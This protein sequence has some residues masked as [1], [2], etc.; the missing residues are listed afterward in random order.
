MKK[1]IVLALLTMT[2]SSCGPMNWFLD[3]DDNGNDMPGPAPIDY[4]TGLLKAFGA[5][6]GLAAGA[7]T[8]GGTAYVSS[9]RSKD[10]L[11]AVVAGIQR[12]KED[13]EEDEKEFMVEKLKKHIPNK[14]HKI[15]GKIKDSI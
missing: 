8:L 4:M 12:F 1:L 5:A 2:L 13:L 9:K 15:I 14:Y 10:P 7:L 3:I 11:K 6:G